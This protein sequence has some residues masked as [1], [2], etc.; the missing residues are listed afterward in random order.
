[1][2][3]QTN[4]SQILWFGHNLM[5]IRV[6]AN[7][8][9]DQISIIECRMPQDISTPVHVTLSEDEIIHVLQG[10][11]RVRVDG[12]VF[13][14]HAGQTIL[15]P[16]GMTHTFTIDAPDGANCLIVTQGSEFEEVVRQ[17]SLPAPSAAVPSKAERAPD[18]TDRIFDNCANNN[19]QVIG[20]PLP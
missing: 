9:S 12:K 8:G 3:A 6:E 10:T 15:A 11:V 18:P 16:K 5:T 17:M 1:M 4:D 19:T 20:A 14:A 2:T 7:A 13:C